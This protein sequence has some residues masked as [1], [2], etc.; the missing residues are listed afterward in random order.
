MGRVLVLVALASTGC[1]TY[2]LVNDPL[3]GWS[4]EGYR[5]GRRWAPDRSQELLLILAFSGGGSRAAAFAYGAL[6]ELDATP[7][8]GGERSLLDEV[9]H[10]SAVSG[11]SFVAAYF[12][13]HGRG[14]F[15]DF[16]Q[17]FLR[18]NVQ[19]ALIG[20]L[21][22][23]WNWVRLASPYYERN[24]LAA[25]YYDRI[26][27]D[28]ATFADLED[29]AGPLVQINATDAATGGPF[30]FIQEQFD[31]LCSDLRTYPIARAVAASSAVP[32]LLSP[33]TLRNFAGSCGF[34]APA[35]V[36][37]EIKGAHSFDRAYVNARNLDSY[38]D[39]RRRRFIR[40]VDGAI[41]DNLG[42]RG[43]FEAA[44][45]R[46]PPDLNERPE[47]VGP[48]RHVVLV[49]VNADK[50]PETAW[51]Q[52]DRSPA[53]SLILGQTVGH[54]V[55]RYNIE[56]LELLRSLFA[57]WNE[58]TAS[59]SPPV[60]FHLVELDFM[61]VG[62]PEER[63]RLNS[64]PTSFRLSDSAVD[65]VVDAGSRVLRESPAFQHFLEDWSGTR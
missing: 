12:G 19:A 49:L 56:T 32:G 15:A 48:L 33:I 51:E 63:R 44:V 30:S 65:A 2:F 53:L 28:G 31:F 16:E 62:D 58:A 36:R 47:A 9:D 43:P 46:G 11:G 50:V 10:L 45:L 37:D 6:K 61:K 22:L 57:L 54:Q 14:V 34:E 29:R 42:V 13:L 5:A 1:S 40:L 38:L 64:L 55:T 20:Q 59:W 60:R 25:R 23:P 4:R 26:L 35:W 21:L 8:A 24:D 52:V 3:E 41:S 18:R 39:S 7:V 17:R 27:F